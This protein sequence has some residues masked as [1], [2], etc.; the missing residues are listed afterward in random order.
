MYYVGIDLGGTNIAAGVVDQDGKLLNKVSVPTNPKEGQEALFDN[1][2]GIVRLAAKDAGL[3]FSEIQGVGV[4]VPGPVD[5]TGRI[6]LTCVNLGWLNVPL[7]NI[8]EEKTGKRTYLAND[9]D[10]AALAEAKVGAARGCDSAI[11]FT[12]GTGL[13]GGFILNGQIFAGANG[14][15]T[16]PGHMPFIFGG[17]PCSC[18]RKGCLERYVSATALIRMT[19]EAMKAN[20]DSLMWKLVDG[21]LEKVDGRT[22]FEADKTGDPAAH[23]V[24][25]TYTEYC[26]AGFAGFIN[27]FHPET[28]VVG[29]GVANQGDY[30][31]SRI[32]EKMRRYCFIPDLIEPPTA[33]HATLG[34]DAGIIGAALLCV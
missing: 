11:M 4:G 27:V 13:G 30:L 9:A 14:A 20:P 1:L 6:A 7:S 23:Q 17:E 25:D 24:I 8:I 26:G 28:V 12:L 19:K 34:N 21:D 2:A 29:G 3:D 22:S 32:N 16:E 15:G 10:V 18:G 33:V 31:M 5:K